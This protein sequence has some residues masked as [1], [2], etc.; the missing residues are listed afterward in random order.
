MIYYFNHS[1]CARKQNKPAALTIERSVLFRC[2]RI[3]SAR[4]L[5]ETLPLFY[6]EIYLLKNTL[7][8]KKILRRIMRVYKLY[9]L[10]YAYTH[11]RHLEYFKYFFRIKFFTLCENPLFSF[12]IFFVY[13]ICIIEIS[14]Q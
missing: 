8:Y 5:G 6:Q 11:I 14:H 10:S 13:F 9:I 12:S 4:K 1:S 7:I 3:Q 2:L